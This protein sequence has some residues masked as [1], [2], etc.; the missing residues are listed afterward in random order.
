MATAVRGTTMKL[1]DVKIGDQQKLYEINE[2]VAS[3][4]LF[5]RARE[6]DPYRAERFEQ[7]HGDWH[8]DAETAARHLYG[9]PVNFGAQ[10]CAYIGSA[11]L[12]TFGPEVLK[13]GL[14]TYVKLANPVRHGDVLSINARAADR[15]ESADGVSVTFDVLVENQEQK[16]CAAAR[17]RAREGAIDIFSEPLEVLPEVERPAQTERDPDT[18]GVFEYEDA[19][20]GDPGRPFVYMVTREGIARYSEGIRSFNPLFHEVEHARQLGYPDVVGPLTYGLIAA[21]NRRWEILRK[22]NLETPH[23]HPTNPHATP[24]SRLDYT[25][26]RPLVPGDLIVSLTRVADKYIRKERKYIAW[27]ITGKDQNDRVV[28]DYIYTCFWGRGKESDRTR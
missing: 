18:D 27:G 21:P 22:H 11:F 23:N 7:V 10:T 1:G 20:V 26:Y 13:G 25:L 9:A 6:A 3:M 14:K 17:V 19:I 16:V 5:T 2:T 28:V 8:T 15:R 12:E 24:F 4:V